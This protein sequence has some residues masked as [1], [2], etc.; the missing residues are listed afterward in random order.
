MRE[1]L[2][3]VF[4]MSKKVESF[5]T[6]SRMNNFNSLRGNKFKILKSRCYL[7]LRTNFFND[8]VVQFT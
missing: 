6:V 2:I 5:T 4:K 1:D 3:H 7:N 8:Y